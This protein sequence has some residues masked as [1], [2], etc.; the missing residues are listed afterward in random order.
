MEP[1]S[2]SNDVAP[3]ENAQYE[4]AEEPTGDASEFV[5]DAL[6]IGYPS[7]DEPVIDGASIRVTP[8][9][10]TALVSPNGSGKSTLLNGLATQ[11]PLEGGTVLLGGRDIHALET[12]EV[13]RKLG[14]LSQENLSPDSIHVEDLVAHGR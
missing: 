12:K 7:T 6:V 5:G 13:A 3:P 1:R 8:G 11:L 14:L 4:P 10:V 9:E 2:R